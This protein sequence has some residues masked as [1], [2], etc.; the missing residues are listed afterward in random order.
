MSSKYECETDLI[1]QLPN[2]I[3]DDDDVG[4]DD[5]YSDNADTTQKISKVQ[6]NPRIH[7]S[8]PSYYASNGCRSRIRNAK[9]GAYYDFYVGDKKETTLFRVIDATGLY[10]NKDPNK[11]Y[12]DC[13][14]EYMEHRYLPV[15]AFT[16]EEWKKKMDNL[17]S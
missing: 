10:G 12:Y 1:N 13:P 17:T 4:T 16:F 7:T 15:D 2:D 11:L 9:T 8:T 6:F 3:L 14:E 5:E